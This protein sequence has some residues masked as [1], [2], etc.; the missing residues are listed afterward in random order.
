MGWTVQ[1][2]NPIVG[3]ISH[4]CLDQ[5]WGLPS[6]LYNGYWVIPGGK[7]ARACHW[8]PTQ[9]SAEVKERV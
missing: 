4:T 2:L 6:L 8:P 7:A 5:P 9:S 3:D 1:G